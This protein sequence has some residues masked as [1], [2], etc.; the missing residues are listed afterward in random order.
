MP[1]LLAASEMLL[2]QSAST[3]WMCSHSAWAR[4]GTGISSS[5][6]GISTSDPPR[7][8]AVRIS[9]TSAGLGKKFTAP[10]LIASIAVEML[11]KPERMRTCTSGLM[12]FRS[13]IKVNPGRPGIRRSTTASSVGS[14]WY[15]S[16]AS[17]QVLA[18]VTRKPRSWKAS[19]SRSRRMVLSSTSMILEWAIAGSI[20]VFM[21]FV[22]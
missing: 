3:R 4:V 14:R 19:A 15:L 2:L 9:S 10:S 5:V 1:S 16:T 12:A 11:P 13:W 6:S 17:S 20:S 22:W 18:T 21:V 8:K 7:L